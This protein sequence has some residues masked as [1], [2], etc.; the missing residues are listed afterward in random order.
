MAK[1][2]WQTVR[3][4]KVNTSENILNENKADVGIS[5]DGKQSN[6]CVWMSPK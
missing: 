4:I 1:D 5:R 2:G 3:A 6:G